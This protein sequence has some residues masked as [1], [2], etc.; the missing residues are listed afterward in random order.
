VGARRRRVSRTPLGGAKAVRRWHAQYL[1]AN[2]FEAALGVAA[3]VAGIVYFIDPG[4]LHQSSIGLGLQNLAIVWSALYFVGGVLMLGG[5]VWASLRMELAGICLFI[6]AMLTQGVVIMLFAGT[7]GVAAAASFIAF[8]A[9]AAVRARKVW[10][11]GNA[12][13]VEAGHE[14]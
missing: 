3:A 12:I 7:R 8:M 5:L 13:R 10:G 1:L 6:P 4:S 2:A 11:L 14:Q 9:A